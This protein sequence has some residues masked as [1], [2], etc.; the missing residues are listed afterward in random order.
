MTND[1][2]NFPS[3][4][5]VQSLTSV[6]KRALAFIEIDRLMSQYAMNK[7]GIETLVA[8]ID[9]IRQTAPGYDYNESTDKHRYGSRS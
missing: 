8:R 3:L 4:I 6:E 1:P 5:A 9:M 7:L 2:F